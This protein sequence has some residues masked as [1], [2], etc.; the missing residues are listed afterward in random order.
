MLT[1][2][3]LSMVG[4]FMYLIMTKKLSASVALIMI[5]ICFAIIAYF[6]GFL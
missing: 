6:L 5:P 4:C 2:I 1:L 3:G